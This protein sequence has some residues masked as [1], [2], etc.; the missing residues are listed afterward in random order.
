MDSDGKKISR[1][2]KLLIVGLI[3]IVAIASV[4]VAVV[5]YNSEHEILI[6]VTGSMD[7]GETDNPISTIPINSMISLRYLTENDLQSVKV[8]DVLGYKFGDKTIVHRVIAIDDVN[9]TFTFKGDANTTTETVQFD[10]V[11]G[12]VTEV[13]PNAGNAITFLRSGPVYIV[14]ELIC[15]FVMVSC[16]REILRIVKEEDTEANQ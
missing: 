1:S 7:A 9:R 16:V 6:V 14:A 2:R 4:T 11:V 3:A 10:K 13:F 12:I 8:G 5:K 15:L